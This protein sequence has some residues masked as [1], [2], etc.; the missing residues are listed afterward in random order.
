[1]RPS[2]RLA[3]KAT[4]PR[5]PVGRCRCVS[6]AVA[7]REARNRKR[8]GARGEGV[9]HVGHRRVAGTFPEVIEVHL[10]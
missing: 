10:R 1:M 4:R 6:P 2:R 5:T 8:V 3:T 7:T 9:S